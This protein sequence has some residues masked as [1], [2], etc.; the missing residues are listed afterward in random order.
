M[1]LTF[2]SLSEE[3]T[4][5]YDKPLKEILKNKENINNFINE[6]YL[7]HPDFHLHFITILYGTVIIYDSYNGDM[8]TIVEYEIL[9]INILFREKKPQQVMI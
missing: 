4:F 6:L 8:N 5:N 9:E 7:Q 2:S 1:L 3:Y